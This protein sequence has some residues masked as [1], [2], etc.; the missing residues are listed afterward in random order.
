MGKW[1]RNRNN[2]FYTFFEILVNEEFPAVKHLQK[3]YLGSKGLSTIIPVCLLFFARY[4][5][6]DCFVICTF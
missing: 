2:N 4:S 3:N 1:N 6:N 5:D